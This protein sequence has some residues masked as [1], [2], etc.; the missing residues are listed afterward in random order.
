MALS[1][2]STLGSIP[3]VRRTGARDSSRT[4]TYKTSSHA[5]PSLLHEPCVR[6]RNDNNKNNRKH[7]Q[8]FKINRQPVLY[9]SAFDAHTAVFFS[10]SSENRVL[11][12]FYGYL[13]FADPAVHA[14]YKR[15]VRD[16]MRY[17]DI[18]FCMASKIVRAIVNEGVGGGGVGG[19]KVEKSGQ[20]PHSP[21]PFI[22]YHIRR[23][24]FQHPQMKIPAEQ[25]IEH[26]RSLWELHGLVPTARP[27]AGV[28]TGVAAGAGAGVAEAPKRVVYIS[29]DEGNRSFFAPFRQ[30]FQGTLILTM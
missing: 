14:F 15:F 10:G 3:P 1:P 27:G 11:T 8:A 24:D 26:T 19:R 5:D 6:V 17:L 20:P 22:A 16:R 4:P 21:A 18:I 23:G 13:F 12:H 30:Y 2:A 29:T 25:I 9:D 7:L 28:D